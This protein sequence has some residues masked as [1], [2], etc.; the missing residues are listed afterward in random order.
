MSQFLRCNNCRVEVDARR[1]Y[2]WLTVNRLEWGKFT[3]Q[4]V[5]YSAVAHLCSLQC[6]WQWAGREKI[7][8]APEPMPMAAPR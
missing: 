3:T 8:P 1:A 4:E 5:V 7:K 6:L 2:D